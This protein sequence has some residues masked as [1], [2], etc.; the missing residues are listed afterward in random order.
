MLIG[1]YTD[2]SGGAI[3]GGYSRGYAFAGVEVDMDW[4]EQRSELI[5]GLL[6]TSSPCQLAMQEA[7]SV[8]LYMA[9]DDS[10]ASG[11]GADSP[12]VTFCL[13]SF[14]CCLLCTVLLPRCKLLNAP[15]LNNIAHVPRCA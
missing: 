13:N 9:Q 2:L 7:V 11:S 14:D 3:Q 10:S 12:Q 6:S 8:L 15:A 4:E 5:D 1:S